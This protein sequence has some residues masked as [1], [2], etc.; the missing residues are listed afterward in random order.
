MATANQRLQ[1][2]AIRHSVELHQY[3]NSIVHKMIAVL[4]RSDARLFSEM[5]DA[6]S[7]LD[8]DSF[9]VG[10][11]QDMLAS[12]RQLNAEAFRA[13]LRELT[14]ELADFLVFEADYQRA[15]LLSVFPVK[16]PVAAVS[17]A[18][19]R[20]AAVSRPFQG[21]LLKGVLNDL[22]AT[23]AKLIR[24]VIAQGFTEGKAIDAIVRELRGT[25]AK[26]YADGL[27][28]RARRD[29][30]AVVRTAIGH[31]AKTV[32]QEMVEKNLDL[33]K[34]LRWTSTLDTRT[35]AFCRIRDGKLY[36]PKT[37]EPV[38]HDLPWGGGPGAAHWNCRSVF[39]PV[40]KSWEELTGVK[41]IPEF[42]PP[43]R[44][45]MD[46]QVPADLTYAD[47]IKQ[48]PFARQVDILGETRARLMRDGGA[49]LGDFYGAKGRYLTLAEM[50]RR[51]A[52]MFERAGL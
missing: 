3:S 15:M 9:T 11:L 24:R 49:D 50:R 43:S 35:S 32:R 16:V 8:P 22:D 30:E 6:L 1:S 21:V 47:W 27:F 10:R 37:H 40:L 42:S 12:V 13:V 17:V 29:V 44:A 4:N 7:R 52:E 18:Q 2:E 26:G 38:G 14:D 34:F 25:R 48:Q 36:D 20:A 23:R 28:N 51:Y 5:I 46:G 41:G 31:Y 39:V 19:V 33:I 45:S